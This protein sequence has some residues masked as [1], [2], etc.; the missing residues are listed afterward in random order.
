MADCRELAGRVDAAVVAVPT[1]A[2][3]EVGC[4]L[5]GGGIDVL[6]EKPIA[7]DLDPRP[8]LVE[9]PNATAASCRWATWSASIRR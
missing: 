3:E 7:P 4:A 2:H 1:T 5:L 9:A 6:V 8:R